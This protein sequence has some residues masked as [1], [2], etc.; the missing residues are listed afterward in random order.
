MNGAGIFY[1][2]YGGYIYGNFKA[3]KIEGTGVL[4]FPNGSVDIGSWEEGKQ[5]GKVL[6]YDKGNEEWQL[7]IYHAGKVK[8]V[9]KS[10]RGHPPISK[11]IST[12]QHFPNPP[13]TALFEDDYEMMRSFL[14]KRNE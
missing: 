4:K 12:H 5:H 11:P 8:E 3:G 9:L 14:T 7:V 10:G 1:F 6:K 13:D 2:A